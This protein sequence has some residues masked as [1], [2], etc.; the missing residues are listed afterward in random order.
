MYLR[1]ILLCFFLLVF[2]FCLEDHALSRTS[3]TDIAEVPGRASSCE[4]PSCVTPD[5]YLVGIVP[6]SQVFSS[7]MLLS[8]H[9]VLSRFTGK[10]LE[11]YGTESHNSSKQ[12]SNEFLE[13]GMIL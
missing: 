4:S 8:V 5:C 7:N 10:P 12:S 11:M 2:T 3:L 13:E 1:L 6:S 9:F